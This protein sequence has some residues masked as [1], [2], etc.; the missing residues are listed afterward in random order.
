MEGQGEQ[1]V[2]MFKEKGMGSFA[3]INSQRLSG[4]LREMLTIWKDE[5][6]NDDTLETVKLKLKSEPWLEHVKVSP[7][8][9]VRVRKA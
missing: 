1:L 9:S 6:K 8:I 7:K 4:Y 2:D 3:T 5:I